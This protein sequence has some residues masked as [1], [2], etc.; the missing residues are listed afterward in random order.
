MIDEGRARR[1]V[2]RSAAGGVRA[3]RAER[4]LFRAA[5]EGD[6]VAVRSVVEIAGRSGHRCRDAAKEA[7]AGWWVASRDPVFRQVVL[8]TEA[9]AKDWPALIQCA[10]LLGRLDDLE[11]G[12][13]AGHLAAL[14]DDSDPVVRASAEDFHRTARGAALN[15]LWRD[16]RGRSLLLR[17]PEPPERAVLRELWEEWRAAPSDELWRALVEWGLP[18]W[19]EFEV[20]TAVIAIGPNPFVLREPRYRTSLIEAI[21]LGDHPLAE[22]A[23]ERFLLVR[24]R[25]LVEVLCRAALRD[26]RLAWFCVRH[27]LMPG[28]RVE[29]AV[30]FLVTGQ[31][32]ELGDIDPDGRLLA[33]GY[34]AAAPDVREAIRDAMAAAGGHDP[35][36]VL[37]GNGRRELSADEARHLAAHLAE[38]EDWTALWGLVRDLPLRVGVDLIRSFDGWLPPDEDR[39]LFEMYLET[40]PSQV[41]AALARM[42]QG[43]PLARWRAAIRFGER[44]NGLSFAPDAPLLAVANGRRTVGVVDLGAARLVERYRGFQASVGCV[45]HV[46]NGTLVAGERARDA[47]R[48]CR[49]MRCAGGE[50]APLHLARG[51]V[52]ALA[53]T[54]DGGAFAA[55]TRSGHLVVGDAGGGP[56][57]TRGVSSLG[58]RRGD[59]PRAIAAH[60]ES[61]RV[62]LLGRRTVLADPARRRPLAAT[63]SAAFGAVFISGDRLACAAREGSIRTLDARGRSLE[64]AQSVWLPWLSGIAAAPNP[65]RLLAVEEDGDLHFFETSALRSLGALPGDGRPTA[66]AVSPDGAFL[67]IVRDGE[68]ADLYDLRAGEL[69]HI[70]ERPGD[71]LE[72]RH[73]RV[74]AGLRASG[75]LPRE[76][77][78]VVA[79]L[80]AA[81][82][83]R[84]GP[85]GASAELST[86]G[87]DI[88]L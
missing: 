54:G 59:W 12:Y 78:V 2:E 31:T 77:R 30:F 39:R 34:A 13:D 65:D 62:A 32:R 81:L 68:R 87:Y 11:I 44:V 20:P 46:G 21:A 86:G 84:F 79:L 63:E 40:D 60:P 72:P 83:H 52:T 45:L 10:A 25:E 19:P 18:A 64:E 5:D 27:R 71:R 74:V 51:S 56:V 1:W 82:E 4:R 57:R 42:A 28:D 76:V 15:A 88:A 9:F 14:L 8:E 49:V 67:A 70:A 7:V 33:A 36:R 58:L 26:R 3:R 23:S 73:L 24:T 29:R 61:G 47:D 48:A 43:W 6:P 55:G 37:T 85:G 16:G 41:E 38:R 53:R 50:T 69:P 22:I 75:E 17:N 80:H 66:V 35:V